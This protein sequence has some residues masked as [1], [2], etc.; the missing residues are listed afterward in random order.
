MQL[1]N[2]IL[3]GDD[4]PSYCEIKKTLL[5]KQGY[6]IDTA[7]SYESIQEKIDTQPFDLVLLDLN[8]KGKSGVDLLKH[9]KNK[10]IDIMVIMI[11]SFATI[12]TA[13]ES[14]KIGA[15]DY[16]TK[17]IENDELLLKIEHAMENRKNTI[18]L[19]TLKEIL[20]ERYSFHNIIGSNKNMQEVYNLINS[21]CN[22]DTPVLIRGETGTGKELVAKAIHFN[23]PRK[24]KPFYAINCAAIS[25]TLTE[26]ELF[27]HEKGAFTGAHK[28]RIGKLEL[29]NGGTVFLD[30]IGDMNISLQAKLLR[31]L[32]DK[33]FERIGGEKNMF[34]DVRIISATNKNLESMMEEKTFRQD[35]FYRI[36]TFQINLPP[37]RERIDDLPLLI[38]HFI[39]IF[40]KK[41]NKAVKGLTE[42]AMRILTEYPWPGNIREL[43]NLIEK[44]VILVS[45]RN[46]DK[47]DLE[48]FLS[49]TNVDLSGVLNTEIPL[50]ELKD[51][52]E[53]EYINTLLKKYHGNI[54]KV[55]MK[56]G[57]S[58]PAIYQKMEKYNLIIKDFK[59]E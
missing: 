10:D 8:L 5:E 51:N 4:D 22:T 42:N 15:Y 52:L 46:I 55:A 57:F 32:Q 17:D 39:K 33:S 38:E 49:K 18:E 26:S 6:I 45:D 7:T 43:E 31:F 2:K 3:I 59:P 35:L 29:A 12:Q 21:I 34:S 53:K 40:N 13:V 56:S 19:R 1:L 25:E 41:Y 27:G 24:E 44:I 14:I 36:N 54:N 30:E 58:R 9:I 50:Q 11:T 23:S 47:D 20:G 48:K 37:L 28:Q 16:L